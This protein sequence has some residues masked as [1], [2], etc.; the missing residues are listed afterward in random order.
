M[1][2]GKGPSASRW[3]I[4][5]VVLA[6]LFVAGMT[7][8][9]L[10]QR[11]GILSGGPGPRMGASSGQEQ[12]ASLRVYYPMEG[13]LK[14]EYRNVQQ[15][16]T[17]MSIARAVLGEFLKGPSG[18]QK[19]YIPRDTRLLGIYAGQDGILY[20]DLS[21][22]FR[23][24]FQGDALEEFLVLRALYGSLLSNVYG[25]GGVKVL[26]EGEEAE[27]IGGHVSLSRPLEEVVSQPMEEDDNQ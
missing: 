26:I 23:R 22:E 20:I 4:T 8:G 6:F 1:S 10:F 15:A 24:N 13:G 11:K 25:I 7:T 21:D 9:Y 18:P 19:S 5:A 2:N 16:Q 3:I 12:T 14:L 27:S 17:R